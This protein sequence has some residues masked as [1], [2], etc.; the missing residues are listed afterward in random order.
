MTVSDAR[1]NDLHELL[2]HELAGQ[3]ES[4]QVL[5]EMKS[6]CMKQARSES[7]FHAAT[8]NAHTM[9]LLADRHGVIRFTT[10]ASE[11]LLG[12]SVEETIGRTAAD[13]V[14]P[15]DLP[16]VL[17]A[18][19]QCL[20]APRA[21]AQVEARLRHRD[22]SVKTVQLEGT[23]LLDEPAV[24]SIVVTMHDITELRA[25]EQEVR[26]SE[27]RLRTVIDSLHAFVGL[28]TPDGAIRLANQTA[29]RAM[30]LTGV[31][32]LL[33]THFADPWL[34]S[35]LH[36]RSRVA[37][38]LANARAGIAARE[39]LKFRTA[40]GVDLIVDFAITPVK[41]EEGRVIYLVPAA[42][43]VTAREQAA[44]ALQQKE[45]E[46]LQAQKMEAVGRLAGGV[47][48][49]FNNIITAVMAF[50][51]I[52]LTDLPADSPSREDAL[53]IRKASERARALTRQLLAF[54]RHQV[55]EPQ[56]LHVGEHMETMLGMLKRLAGEDVD[57]ALHREDDD[58]PIFADPSQVEQ[59]VLNLVVNARDAMPRG[60][61]VDISV[62]HEHRGGDQPGAP[63]DWI[64][65]QV[66]DQGSGM[67]PEVMQHVF[68]PFYTTKPKGEGTGLGLSTVYGI[69]KQ[70]GGFIEL[71][72]EVGKGTTFSVYLPS[73]DE[74]WSVACDVDTRPALPVGGETVLLVEDDDVVRSVGRRVLERASFRVIEAGN[75]VEGLEIL[76]RHGNEVAIVISDIVMPQMSGIEMLGR[77]PALGLHPALLVTSG[78]TEETLVHHGNVPADAR[79]LDKPFTAEAL[80]EAVRAA[81]WSRSGMPVGAA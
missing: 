79:Y 80:L 21:R 15:A 37:E 54:S 35:D 81:L 31:E 64:R 9:M 68:E 23:N 57:I 12:I 2:V 18:L 67:P 32:G 72:S 45:Q 36:S 28:L 42:V 73:C 11:S 65:L 44:A 47:A 51:D 48:H 43:D 77:I 24:R 69:V 30:G 74:A 22:G 53:E 20:S 40:D 63:G 62:T 55:M 8:E 25:R 34:W 78:Y 59:V 7:L 4:D 27:Q 5:R 56:V 75:G 26:A 70:S 14:L 17:A 41:D 58:T 10:R 76:E 16:K 60:G 39:D 19:G 49:D 66:A 71:E 1:L 3:G 6:A 13:F 33:G 50:S 46:L 61:R 29:Y 38:M 52:L